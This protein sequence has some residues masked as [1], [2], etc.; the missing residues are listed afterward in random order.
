MNI[1]LIFRIAGI[2]IIVAVLNLLL[3]KSGRD[4]QALMTTLAGLVVVMLMLIEEIGNLFATVKAVFG[5]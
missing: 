2:G 1:D 3:S 4:E 5:L